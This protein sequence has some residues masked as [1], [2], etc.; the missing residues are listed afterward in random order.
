VRRRE[1]IAL[2]GGAAAWPLA[3]QAQ[4]ASGKM[5]R[6]GV[7]MG[8]GESDPSGRAFI[9]SF[10]QGIQSFGWSDGANVRV[11][12]RWA[13]GDVERMRK[14]AKEL[15][16]LQPDV[17]FANT[18]PVTAALARGTRAISIVFGIVSDPVGAGFVESLP[19]P[20]GNI[21][22]FINV[23]AAMSGKWLELLKDA[24]APFYLN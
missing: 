4:Q 23:E 3:A 22:G 8:Y 14:F 16:E 11:D 7:L 21:T 12:V 24:A 13:V 9:A 10:M 15:V 6:I 2:L 17:I 5:R 20:G 18:T 1:F 19:R